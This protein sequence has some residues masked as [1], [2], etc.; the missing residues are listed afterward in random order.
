[1]GYLAEAVHDLVPAEDI[2]PLIKHIIINFANESQTGEKVIMGINC[3]KEI[4][5]RNANIIS[6]EDLNFVAAL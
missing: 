6:D 3:I 4:C 2:E 1:M 5:Y